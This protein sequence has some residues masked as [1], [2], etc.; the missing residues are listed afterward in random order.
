MVDKTD[1]IPGIVDHLKNSGIDENQISVIKVK[2][3]GTSNLSKGAS[4]GASTGGMIGGALGILAGAGA[5][6]IPGIGPFIATGPVMATLS[7]IISGSAAGAGIGSLAGAL[8]GLGMAEPYAQN[9][10]SLLKKGSALIATEVNDDAN[11][12]QVRTIYQTE[13]G[14]D[15]AATEESQRNF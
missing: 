14:H 5:L 6:T 9:Y 10:E 15:I 13:G 11:V 1:Q 2:D 12:N 8:V 3:D 7:S 4:S